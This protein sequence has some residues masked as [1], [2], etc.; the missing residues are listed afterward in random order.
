MY[1]LMYEAESFYMFQCLP[2]AKKLSN[3]KLWGHE[4]YLSSLCLANPYK[5]IWLFSEKKT[6]KNFCLL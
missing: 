3:G 5:W 4:M 1:I 2:V 6:K